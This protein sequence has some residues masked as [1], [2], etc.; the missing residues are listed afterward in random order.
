MNLMNIQQLAAEYTGVLAWL[1]RGCRRWI[2]ANGLDDPAEVREAT[3]SYR[4]DEDPLVDFIATRLTVE[5]EAFATYAQIR[6]AYRQWCE[7]ESVKNGMGDR[8]LIA[9]LLEIE[10]TKKERRRAGGPPT[11]GIVGMGVLDS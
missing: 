1:V 6:V 2:E 10:G 11:R 8:A 9:R 3:E 5:P 7:S 4:E